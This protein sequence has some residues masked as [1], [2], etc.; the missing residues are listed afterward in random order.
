VGS[1]ACAASCLICATEEMRVSDT[2]V[3]DAAARVVYQRV[4]RAV[5][6]ESLVS[7]VMIE[8]T[9]H[10]LEATIIEN[11]SI[12]APLSHSPG[13]TKPYTDYLADVRQFPREARPGPN[14]FAPDDFEHFARMML[15]VALI[16][17]Q[18]THWVLARKFN[19]NYWVMN[20]DGGSNTRMDDLVTWMNSMPNPF[21]PRKIGGVPYIFTGIAVR[22]A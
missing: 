22:A 12:T 9:K 21:A 8:I 2:G 14:A 1:K 10:R 18:L 13:F 16:P 6:D 15:V 20:P 17:S 4:W 5:N 19:G 11:L 7:K 3:S